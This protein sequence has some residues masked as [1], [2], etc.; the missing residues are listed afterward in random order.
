[1]R[2]V[3]GQRPM[4]PTHPAPRVTT[5]RVAR[6]IDAHRVTGSTATI[7]CGIAADLIDARQ[8]LT[9][10][11]ETAMAEHAELVAARERVVELEAAIANEQGCGEPPSLGW[12]F[13]GD[14]HWIR[15]FSPRVTGGVVGEW[16]IEDATGPGDT[17]VVI[18]R[19]PTARDAMRAA[20]A[21]RGQE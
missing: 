14:I 1:M 16:L 10:V 20:D 8:Q 2:L 13:D 12:A 6:Y 9:D 18:G 7:G 21:A 17:W 4:P 19:A 3:A 15:P 5:E 11:V